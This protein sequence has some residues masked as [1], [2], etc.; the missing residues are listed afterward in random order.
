LYETDGQRASSLARS[1][2]RAPTS[3]TPILDKVQTKGLIERRPEPADRR[4][5]NIYL[6][7]KGKKLRKPIQTAFE[8]VDTE[9]NNRIPSDLLSGFEAG[10]LILHNLSSSSE[11]VTDLSVGPTKIKRVR[12]KH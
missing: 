9:A 8:Q 6:T 1:V 2:G 4:A 7:D 3:F 11:S 10:L 12:R 5:I